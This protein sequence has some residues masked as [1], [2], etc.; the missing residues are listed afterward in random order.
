MVVAPP[1][2]NEQEPNDVFSQAQ[3]LPEGAVIVLGTHDGTANTG[4]VYQFTL[5]AGQIVQVTLET[6]NATGVQLLAYGG[7]APDEI[8]RDFEAPHELNFVATTTGTY[9]LYVFTPGT[10]NNAAAYT[11]TLRLTE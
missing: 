9:Y 2:V 4:D 5:E 3:T 10:A 7:E 1:R 11:L 6:T 8:V